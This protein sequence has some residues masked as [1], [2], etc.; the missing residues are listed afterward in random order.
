MKL[1]KTLF[2]LLVFP[3]VGLMV[4]GCCI[5]C[6][7][8]CEYITH[9]SC[10]IS[11]LS[12]AQVVNIG[13]EFPPALTEIRPELKENYGVEMLFNVEFYEDSAGQQVLA[14][15]PFSD[16]VS[17]HA[18]DSVTSIQ[19]FSN[20]EFS[21]SDSASVDVTDCFKIW[22]GAREPAPISQHLSWTYTYST[23]IKCLLTSPPTT[24]GQY[25]F[26]VVA[27][28]SDGRKLEQSIEAVLR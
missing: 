25:T 18:K 1:L 5:D 20:K 24:A 12:L 19:I 28:L 11:S 2:F 21:T 16:C 10:N 9:Y 13:D 27:Q 6:D 17:Y 3:V 14:K 7:R 23:A 4:E 22:Q 8:E 26:T 15:F